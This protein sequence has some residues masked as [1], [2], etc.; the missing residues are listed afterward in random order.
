MG[1]ADLEKLCPDWQER[2]AYLSGPSEMLD[3]FTEHWESHGDCDKLHMERFQ[4]KLGLGE[5]GDG[6]GGTIKFLESDCEVECDGEHADPRGRRGSR[7]RPALR[8]PG[9]HL[10][11]LR[12]ASF[13]RASC[14]ICETETSTA[15]RAR[16]CEPASARQRVPSRSN[17]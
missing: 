11:H 9:G 13:A 5:G 3:A 7:A 12:R 17:S 6:E 14:G 16:S 2:D 1:P 4:P 8:L 10:P 15:T